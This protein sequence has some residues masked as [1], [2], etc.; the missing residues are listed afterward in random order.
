MTHPST[1]NQ[2]FANAIERFA[3]ERVAFAADETPV[4]FGD[5]STLVRHLES[6][7]RSL[8]VGAGSVVGYSLPNCAEAIAFLPALA[9]LGACAVPLFPMIPAPARA[10]IFA[11]LGCSV[12]VTAGPN[13]EALSEA[14]E[15][16]HANYRVVD[17]AQLPDCTGDTNGSSID[18]PPLQNLLVAASSG[19]TGVPKSVWISHQ[20][21]AAAVSAAGDMAQLGPWQTNADYSSV[22]AFPL[23]TS[24]VLVVLGCILRGVRLIFSRDLSPVR[25]LH[26]AA[27]WNVES[28]SAPPS[29]FENLLALPTA[30]VPPTPRVRA[31]LTGMDFLSTSLLNRL[32]ER[33]P[34]LECAASGYGLVETS[35]VFMTW[36]AHNR[37]Q[38]KRPPNVF[39]L[40]PSVA[41][42]TEIRDDLGQMV[43]DGDPGEL[44]VKGHSVVAGY[45]GAQAGQG[46][47]NGGWF[48]T[49]DVA[50][51]CSS[52]CIELLGRQK[53]LIKRGGKSVSPLEVQARVESCAGVKAAAVV[54]V[55]QPLFGEMIW[56]FV[57]TDSA[58]PASLTDIMSE[59]R[60]NLPSY[61][62]PDRVHF[63]A[64]LPRGAGVGKI[65]REALIRL[66]QA[67]LEQHEGVS[68]E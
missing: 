33:F 13:S 43:P 44:C 54:G 34:N 5:L 47:F 21:A 6:K 12:V 17:L 26:L 64:E 49:G 29:Y 62:V 24:S 19:T 14:A 2:H 31:V 3:P 40:C 63:I 38:L 55:R 53:Y 68:R 22:I 39:E 65:D 48:S 66:A 58:N 45:L 46:A 32:K 35:T 41:N 61:M 50:R 16:M 4:T 18:V 67:D 51:V 15:R 59:C 42:V 8:G 10:G 36:K 23:S 57:V 1:L 25:Y 11:Q 20:N 56:A 30:I 37:E 60:T 52:G 9:H 7:L 27:H 28:L